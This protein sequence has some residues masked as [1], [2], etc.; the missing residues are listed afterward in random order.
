MNK[1]F[2]DMNTLEVAAAICSKLD[3]LG[4]KTT[5]SG[6][7]CA[8][9][10]SCGEY[11][12]M[13]IDLINQY[14]EDHKKIVETMIEFGFTQKGKDFY[15]VDVEYSIEFPCG[16]P[17]V[18]FELIK[19][20]AEIETEAGVL[21]ILRATDCVKDR[22]CGFYHWEEEASLEQALIVALANDIDIEDIKNW[23]IKEESEEK[24]NIFYQELK[25]RKKKSYSK[26]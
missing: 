2:K 11:T 12:S 16:P 14:N 6:G 7:Y 3:S 4:I 10:Y 17:T 15:H 1:T 21:R 24:F 13:D 9:I 25:K 19:D 22:L 5:L 18:G 20:V 8:E 23:S 26:S